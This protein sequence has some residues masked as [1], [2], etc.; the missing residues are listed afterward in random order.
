MPKQYYTIR[1][2]ASGINSL[3]DPRDLNEDES[4][5][6][7]NMSIDA[8]GK[9]KTAGVLH[10]H[11]ANPSNAGGTLSNY[12]SSVSAQLEQGTPSNKG[13]GYNLAYFEADHSRKNEFND[14]GTTTFTVG[15]AV[16]NI[17]F[18]DPQNTDI[19]GTDTVAPGGAAGGGAKGTE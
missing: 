5:F 11:S 10:A 17:S 6:I 7:K 19:S 1:S 13:G 2:F 12:I 16:G 3:K 8:Q 9:I 18:I 15:V 14:D 4:S